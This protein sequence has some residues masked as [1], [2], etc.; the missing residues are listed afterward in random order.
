MAASSS[1]RILS[2]SL[3]LP[4]AELGDVDRRAQP[5]RHGQHH[6][7]RRDRERADQQGQD[8][9]L[10]AGRRTTA[11]SWVLVKNSTRFSLPNSTGAASRNTKK[12]IEN[13]KR[14]ALQPQRRI[15]PF[16]Q[17]ARRDPDATRTTCRT[18]RVGAA[19]ARRIGGRIR[20][21]T[22]SLMSAS[23]GT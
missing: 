18:E 4:R 8:A 2:V 23:T 17:P 21:W 9:V 12:K 5:Q 20:A 3:S 6:R 14:I 10:A 1:M 22:S 13:T 16:D 19:G 15:S 7:Q 11:A